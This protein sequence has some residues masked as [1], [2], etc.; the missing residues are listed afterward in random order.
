MTSKLL[1]FGYFKE[2]NAALKGRYQLGA[3]NISLDEIHLY[4]GANEVPLTHIYHIGIQDQV[5]QISYW[6]KQG[7]PVQRMLK[8]IAL[9]SFFYGNTRRLKELEN[10][11]KT[12]IHAAK[13][14]MLLRG[15]QGT[16]TQV[17]AGALGVA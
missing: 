11:L 5:L 2:Q 8:S 6:D 12:S 1:K 14:T 3:I 4:L 9:L 10:C 16:K 15:F 7:K 17:P 13:A